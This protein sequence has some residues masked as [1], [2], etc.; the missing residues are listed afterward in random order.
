LSLSCSLAVPLRDLPRAKPSLEPFF[1]V[2]RFFFLLLFPGR[3]LPFPLPDVPLF[4]CLDSRHL[5]F[6]FLY[7]PLAAYYPHRGSCFSFFFFFVSLLPPR[8]AP[9]GF[10]VVIPP[11]LSWSHSFLYLPVV[12]LSQVSR[13]GRLSFRPRSS[14][15]FFCFAPR[16]C[17]ARRF[18]H[19]F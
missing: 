6:F 10:G 11:W 15:F 4:P 7:G 16:E 13:L 14:T 12:S 17:G 9:C 3:A 2:C 18:F 8:R 1:L 5:I 19:T